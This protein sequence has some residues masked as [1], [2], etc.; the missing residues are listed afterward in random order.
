VNTVE[1]FNEL[2][3]NSLYKRFGLY[4]LTD[5]TVARFLELKHLIPDDTTAKNSVI[6]V[7][8][9]L[10]VNEPI[11]S[12]GYAQ[13]ALRAKFKSRIKELAI[14]ESSQRLAVSELII[15]HISELERIQQSVIDRDQSIFN[16][17]RHHL[18]MLD[19][20]LKVTTVSYTLSKLL[21]VKAI[22]RN[23]K[24]FFKGMHR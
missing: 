21:K 1:D 16:I 22:P 18:K 19:A 17:I 8:P 5:K 20:G 14:L 24:S 2:D 4:Q 12:L 3:L 11:F 15:I 7:Y 6:E 10:L 13:C 9:I 23:T